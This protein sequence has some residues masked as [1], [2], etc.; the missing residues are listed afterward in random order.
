MKCLFLVARR[1]IAANSHILFVASAIG[2][3]PLLLPFA[4]GLDLWPYAVVRSV[5]SVFCAVALPKVAVEHLFD[6]A[7]VGFG[8][9]AQCAE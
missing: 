1:E 3:L 7:D 8:D 6:S 5:S 2:L 9:S 4:P